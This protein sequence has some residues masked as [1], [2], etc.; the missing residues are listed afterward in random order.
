MMEI[1][2]ARRELQRLLER[3]ESIVGEG[4]GTT[5]SVCRCAHCGA[6]ACRCRGRCG[7]RSS[8]GVLAA[9]AGVVG[10]VAVTKAICRT[11]ESGE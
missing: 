10:A 8:W 5:Q 2:D 6:N 9:I 11:H 3:I 7:T 4:A 1:G